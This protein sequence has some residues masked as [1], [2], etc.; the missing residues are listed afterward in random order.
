MPY[1][2]S[3]T[4]PS[5][6]KIPPIFTPQDREFV[7]WEPVII[8]FEGESQ[9]LYIETILGRKYIWKIEDVFSTIAAKHAVTICEPGVFDSLLQWLNK[10][11]LMWM[12]YDIPAATNDGTLYYRGNSLM[13][14]KSHNDRKY[15]WNLTRFFTFDQEETDKI[16]QDLD[17]IE[18]FTDLLLF[19]LE[20]HNIGF[21]SL[22]SPSS[23][24]RHMMSYYSYTEFYADRMDPN[25]LNS[26][27][28]SARGARHESSGIGSIPSVN[29]DMNKA[30][31]NILTLTPT[32]RHC[33]YRFGASYTNEASYGAYLI[34]AKIPNM[35][36]PP[37]PVNMDNMFNSGVAY[38]T[39]EI[40]GWYSK[41]H[42]TILNNLKI[43]YKIRE[44]HE[45][46]PLGPAANARP[47][48]ELVNKVRKFIDMAPKYLNAK[49]LYHGI[50]GSTISHKPSL[51]PMTGEV[52]SSSFN[53]FNP[54]IYGHILG[55]QAQRVYEEVG[56][57]EP[58]AIRADAVTV[59]N[60]IKTSLRKEDEGI[61]TFFTSLYKS[62]PSGKGDIWKELIKQNKNKPNITYYSYG[63]PTL[64]RA[65]NRGIK[66]GK[67][68]QGAI[69]VKPSQGFRVGAL[70]KN[71]GQL[72]EEW[73]PS[74]PMTVEECKT[75]K[76]EDI[77]DIYKMY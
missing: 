50:A 64:Y 41:P 19:H 35:V 13:L 44:S 6:L 5:D 17:M 55:T 38:P 52:F 77:Y 62:F 69:N 39:G 56:K 33:A 76:P 47:F 18:S 40:S 24:A 54:L 8:G 34:T 9:K 59:G 74:R 29:Y 70:P 48:V 15:I 4:L 16:S 60:S 25:I 65:V 71:V 32:V 28:Q 22:S 1:F 36:L 27:Y 26:F 73:M 57:G 43:P 42:L 20:K 75:M 21:S 72:L 7:D 37:L 61:T 45:Y 67:V 11:Q 63:Y 3:R 51:N 2:D 30:H 68:I 12:L 10:K 31:L 23:V 66:L 58:I 53:V 46:I 49:G 14:K